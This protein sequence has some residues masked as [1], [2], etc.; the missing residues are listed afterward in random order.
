[1]NQIYSIYINEAFV[2]CYM[3]GTGTTFHFKAY[4]V[5]FFYGRHIV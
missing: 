2:M 3:H 1:M 4:C 5:T